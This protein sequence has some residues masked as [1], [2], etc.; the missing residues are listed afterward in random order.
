M[1]V[2]NAEPF[3][4]EAVES[5]LNQTFQDFEFIIVDDGSTDGSAQI[6]DRY[7][8]S[9]PR[10]VVWR[11]P[12]NRGLVEAHNAGFSL[13]TG[14]YIALMAADDIA[15]R[16]RLTWQFDFMEKHPEVGL[17]GGAVEWIDSTGKL[18]LTQHLPLKD[19][20]IRAALHYHCQFSAPTVFL[21]K[22]VFSTTYGFRKAFVK[23]EDYDLWLRMAERCQMANLDKVLLQY[24]IHLGQESH[25]KVRQMTFCTLAAQA[26]AL[27]R[28][29]GRPDLLNEVSE[30][31]PAVLAD[32]GVSEA[33]LQRAVAAECLSV[34]RNMALLGVNSATLKSSVDTLRFSHWKYAEKNVIA[35]AWLATATCY[36][37][38]KRFFWSLHAIAS[39]V[40]ARP[41]T[42][43]RPLKN[44]LRALQRTLRAQDVNIAR[45]E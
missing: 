28:K 44:L 40:M 32:L 8:K 18:L 35:D 1:C 13:A 17:L 41:V 2:F 10:L 37:R 31:T 22:D 15:V 34:I 23:A 5:I 42:A 45:T 20:E 26:S 14:K 9:D 16:D 38:Q 12:K 3:L 39:A 11:H 43:G 30:V 19:R 25:N 21:R 29:N 24:R 4:A 7:R 27:A 6:I 36:W 33:M